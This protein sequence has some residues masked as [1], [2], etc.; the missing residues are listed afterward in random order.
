MLLMLLLS[1][2]SYIIFKTIIIAG[3]QLCLM[4]QKMW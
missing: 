2:F 4:S 1:Q 3:T